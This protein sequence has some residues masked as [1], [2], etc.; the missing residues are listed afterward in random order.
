MGN[1]THTHTHKIRIQN[2]Q[3]EDLPSIQIFWNAIIITIGK[4]TNLNAYELFSRILL[5]LIQHSILSFLAKYFIQINKLY[6]YLF[7]L[8]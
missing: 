7:V 8:N 1:N 4:Q 2:L 6:A 5:L 3:I